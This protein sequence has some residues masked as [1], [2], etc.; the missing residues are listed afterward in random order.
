VKELFQ[1]AHGEVYDYSEFVFENVTTPSKIICSKHG[2]FVQRPV[3][4]YR[5]AGCPKCSV[6][7]VHDEQK[8]DFDIFIVRAKD[9]HG[10]KYVYD[11]ASFVDIFTPMEIKCPSHGGFLQ[12][13]RD[14][15]RGS[16]CPQCL[17][18]K[19]ET[20]IRNILTRVGVKFE[21]QKKFKGMAHKGSLRCDF[22]LPNLN[23]VIEFNGKQHYEPIEL[24]GGVEGLKRTQIRDAVKYEFLERKGIDLLIFSNPIDEIESKLVSYLENYG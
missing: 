2:V 15:Y 17:S 23:C 20:V 10:E 4:H 3:S 11:K 9:F 13:P 22:Y 14:H 7:A 12:A 18:S 5:G 6:E 21:E 19:G 24:F 16:G 1:K 8:I